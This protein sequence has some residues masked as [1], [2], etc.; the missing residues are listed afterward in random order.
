MEFDGNGWDIA[1]HVFH[2]DLY[3]VLRVTDYHRDRPPFII[4]PYYQK[5]VYGKLKLGKNHAGMQ[6]V[7]YAGDY[8]FMN[9]ESHSKA[10]RKFQTYYARQSIPCLTK[11]LDYKLKRK[12]H[13]QAHKL[14]IDF[15]N[16]TL[17]VE[18]R[19]DDNVLSVEV[20]V[21]QYQYITKAQRM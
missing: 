21:P 18:K 11:Y 10:L 7:R 13:R 8:I 5:L 16:R 3:D 15:T 1:W 19:I 6:W 12:I 17:V 14:H 2:Q 9:V 4:T 20:C